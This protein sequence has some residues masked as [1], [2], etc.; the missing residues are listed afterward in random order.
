MFCL[1]EK[2]RS[3]SSRA[4]QCVQIHPD[5]KRREKK[6]ELFIEIEERGG[7]E[8][9]EEERRWNGGGIDLVRERTEEIMKIS[10]KEKAR[11]RDGNHKDSDFEST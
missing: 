8:G 9:K 2:E 11:R 3:E 10:R 1:R 4:L 7:G 5:K 6:R